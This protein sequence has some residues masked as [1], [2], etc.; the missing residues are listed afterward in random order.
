MLV[1]RRWPRGVSRDP[2]PFAD[3]TPDVAPSAQLHQWHRNAP[4][5]FDEFQRRYRR[6]LGKS[7]AKEALAAL[8]ARAAEETLV[9]VTAAKDVDR[10]GAA[11][12]RQVLTSP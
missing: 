7:P 9:L 5:R 8:R 4:A 3:W 2:S 1:D 6:E 10:S 12:L 11:V